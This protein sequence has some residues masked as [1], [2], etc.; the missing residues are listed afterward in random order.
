MYVHTH[1]HTHTIVG[2]AVPDRAGEVI[3]LLCKR[4]LD[5]VRSDS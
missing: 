4:A 1:T 3:D 2:R 5:G